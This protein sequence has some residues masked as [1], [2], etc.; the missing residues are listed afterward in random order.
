MKTTESTKNLL[1]NWAKW[2]RMAFSWL[3]NLHYLP[4]VAADIDDNDSINSQID[5]VFASIE[6][7]LAKRFILLGSH[8]ASFHQF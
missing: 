1:I 5:L 7:N 3:K 6:P 8:Q 4:Q 2:E